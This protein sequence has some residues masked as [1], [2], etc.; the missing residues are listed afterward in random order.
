MFFQTQQKLLQLANNSSNE[1]IIR[2]NPA[3][4]EAPIIWKRDASYSIQGDNGSS[5]FTRD[6]D[7]N[8]GYIYLFFP[9]DICLSVYQRVDAMPTLSLPTGADDLRQ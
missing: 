4:P 6:W 5:W 1:P 9:P 3:D 2:G 7:Q 8:L